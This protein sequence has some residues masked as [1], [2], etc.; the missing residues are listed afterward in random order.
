MASVPRERAGCA[1]A[2]SNSFRQLGGALGTAVLGGVLS[3]VYRTQI[4]SQLAALPAGLRDTA[5][6]SIQETQAVLG[7]LGSRIPDSAALTAASDGAFEIG[8]HTSSFLGAGVALVG[9]VV[10]ALTLTLRGPLDGSRAIGGSGRGV[11]DSDSSGCRQLSGALHE[12]DHYAV[13]PDNRSDTVSLSHLARFVDENGSVIDRP[14]D[15]GFETEYT[16]VR[17]RSAGGTRSRRAEP[18]RTGIE[19]FAGRLGDDVS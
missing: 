6:A 9:A 15:G 12:P 13:G 1:S 16:D 18:S 19:R 10:A 2:T 11:R 4:T 3:G 14:L 7:D 17:D 5:A 8:F